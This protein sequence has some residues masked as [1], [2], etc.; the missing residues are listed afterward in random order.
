M[1]ATRAVV[2][3]SA[4]IVAG[5]GWGG[6]E[7]QMSVSYGEATTPE[8]IAGYSLMRESA[9][10]EHVA[11]N[12]NSSLKLPYDVALVGEQCGKA[13]AYWSVDAK[14]ITVCYEDADLTLMVFKAL[15]DA[16]PAPAAANAELTTVYHE[17]GH[18][19]IDFYGL[20]V[21]GQEEDAA[22][23]F[24]VF[25]MLHPGIDLGQA[26]GIDGSSS[27]EVQPQAVRSAIDFARLFKGYSLNQDF[28]TEAEFA[29]KHSLSQE[30][31]YNVL[32]WVYGAD[33]AKYSDIV[34]DGLLP[35]SRADG[36]Q[37]EYNLLAESWSRL[38]KPY[39]KNT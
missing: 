2:L 12:V 28:V 10:L 30:R 20:P 38:L 29:T 14:K 5:C 16:D 4:L 18:A 31:T 11:E 39:L 3:I 32:C 17:L 13:N 19:V 1:F 25:L 21:L 24:V 33:P 37:E 36:C 35:K 8:A 6:T 27:G 34:T 9:L 7:P 22:D 23:G 15:G 26:I